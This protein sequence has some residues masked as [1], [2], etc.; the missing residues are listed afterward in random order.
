M[1]AC[2]SSHCSVIATSDTVVPASERTQTVVRSLNNIPPDLQIVQP[3]LRSS[4]LTTGPR[5]LFRIRGQNIGTRRNSSTA[6]RG[7]AERPNNLQFWR[8]RTSHNDQQVRTTEG[9]SRPT[10]A[11]NDIEPNIDNAVETYSVEDITNLI[12]ELRTMEMLFQSLFGGGGHENANRDFFPAMW[13]YDPNPPPGGP[14]PASDRAMRQLPNVV[15]TQNDLLDEANR[16]CCICFCDVNLGDRLTRLPCG[17]LYHRPC[18]SEWLRKHCTCPVCRYELET[19]DPVY[20]RG[21]VERMSSRKLRYHKYELDRMTIRE[22]HELMRRIN[23][24][25]RHHVATEKSELIDFIMNSGKIDV[26]SVAPLPTTIPRYRISELRTLGIS[27]LK[28][29]MADSGVF[30]DASDVVEKEDMVQIFV[31]SG[32]VVILAE[33]N[34]TEQTHTAP[35][36]ERN[37]SLQP[38]ESQ[39]SDCGGIIQ[40]EEWEMVDATDAANNTIAPPTTDAMDTDVSAT[41]V[42]VEEAETASSENST[43]R[44]D[45]TPSCQS[46]HCIIPIEG[47]TS[48]LNMNSRNSSYSSTSCSTLSSYNVA[49][50]RQLTYQLNVSLS[51]CLEKEEMINRIA[52]A[53]WTRQNGT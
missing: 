29:V 31:N 42:A 9:S 21:R 8:F 45:E 24:M 33:D 43:S 51:G 34:S 15:V 38:L 2:W 5:T 11:F 13:F 22:L 7:L 16:E 10:F 23:L 25:D 46:L 32:R 41:P 18:I 1:G 6:T 37:S 28:K 3:Q 48:D 12:Q 50:L 52:T 26:I 27:K 20:E 49:Q 53:A 44:E 47:S 14:P 35:S 17:H 40:E 19:D 39:S 30:F 4:S 36:L